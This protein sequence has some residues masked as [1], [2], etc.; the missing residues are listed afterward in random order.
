MSRQFPSEKLLEKVI[1]DLKDFLPYLVLVG[2]W[3]PYLYAKYI[4][5]EDIRKKPAQDERLVYNFRPV[6]TTTDMDFG[7]MVVSYGG[8]E[9]IANRVQ[10]LG[11]GERHLAMDRSFPF[12]PVAKD[13]SGNEK[14]EVEFITV[15]DPP[16]AIKEKLVGREIKLETLPYFN[17]LLESPIT[18]VLFSCQLQIPAESIFIFHKLLTFVERENKEK[19]RKDLYYIYYMLRF[20]PNKEDVIIQI[21]DLIKSRKEGKAVVKNIRQYF[22]SK[23]DK[24]PVL[25]EQENGPDDLIDD[26]RRDA[27]DRIFGILSG[28]VE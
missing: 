17:I 3:I 5:P 9:S 8:S 7:V 21:R 4:W 13:R 20:S 28:E 12:V 15:L 22:V 2:G 19:L 11:Y 23:D 18:V 14:A 6:I 25:I 26:V 27:Y 10:K 24:G 1:L 16:K